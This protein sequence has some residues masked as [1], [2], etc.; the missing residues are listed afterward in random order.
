MSAPTGEVSPPTDPSRRVAALF[1]RVAPTY[2]Q[3]GV[4]FFRPIAELLVSALAPVPGERVLDV[5]CGRGAVTFR[6]AE[7]VRPGGRVT[8]IDLAPG[9]VAATAA[10]AES[11]GY[12]HVEVLAGDAGDPQL[13]A[14]A[15]D[16]IA[17]SLVVFFLPDPAAALRHWL[18]LL[19]AGGRL[20]LTTFGDQHDVWTAVDDLFRPYLPPQLLDARTTGATGPFAS[21]ASVTAL[22]RDAGFGDVTTTTTRLPVRFASREQWH[23]FSWSVGQRLMWEHVPEHERVDVRD[24]AYAELA[25]ATA[26]DGS[27]TLWQDVR[28]TVGRR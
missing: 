12:D 3:V 2:D 6:A 25:A 27:V 5:G 14:G 20:G 16:V 7:A 8:A 13:P 9:M 26:D 19:R 28:V 21:E 22:V 17:S 24:R 18:P 10:D 11:R 1:D 4:D 15:Y 23:E